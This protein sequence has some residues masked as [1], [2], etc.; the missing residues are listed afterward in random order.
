LPTRFTWPVRVYWED[1]DAQ[2]VVY[3]ANYL[4]FM[5]RCR[6]EWLRSIGVDQVS[7]RA[8]QGLIFVIVSLDAEYRRPARL[9]DELT[10]TCEI[11]DH[12]RTNFT[13]RQQIFRGGDRAELLVTGR[14]RA[15]C[16]DAA[17][18]KPRAFPA[19]LV[20]ELEQ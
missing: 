15:A 17:S 2:G 3:Y 10:V 14:T 16:I 4:K 5:E 1:T 9:D 18:M 20:K 6:T 13:F 8:Q 11:E 19:V 12:G 7:M